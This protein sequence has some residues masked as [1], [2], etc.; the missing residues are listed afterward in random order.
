MATSQHSL[1][2]ILVTGANSGIGL[3]L[4]K[5]LCID[6]GVHVYLGARDL[7][8]GAMAVEEVKAA[9]GP[10]ASIDLIQIDVSSE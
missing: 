4:C 5:Q 2:K 7:A 1:R 9:A 8:R 6:Y 10:D 3:A